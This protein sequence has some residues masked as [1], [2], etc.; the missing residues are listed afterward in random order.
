VTDSGEIGIFQVRYSNLLMM[1]LQQEQAILRGRVT[2]KAMSGAKQISPVQFL[3][4]ISTKIV[5]SRLNPIAATPHNYTRYWVQPTD[6]AVAQYVDTFDLLKTEI[7]PKSQL[8]A[9]AASACG[10]DWDD[11]IIRAATAAST[12]GTDGGSLTTESFDTTAYQ[13][14]GQFGASAAV[15]LTVAKLNEAYRIFEK[16]HI[17]P[18]QDRITLVIGSSEHR[19]LK[20]QAQVVSSD[21]NRN[22][23]VL[24]NGYVSEFMG[25]DIV[26]SERLPTITDKDSNAN[27]RGCLAFVKQGIHLNMWADLNTKISQADW[28][29]G[30]PWQIYT[31]HSF[32]AVRGQPGTV[33]QIAAADAYGAD[34]TP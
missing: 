33:V 22:G 8:V 23:G 9:S 27:Q 13:V 12:I 19:D 6:K 28:L 14:S 3:D 24:T 5:S 34:T 32:G 18:R 30:H 16:N 20:N 31:K 25:M 21:F 11:E 17:N 1:K 4:A 7:D 29:E 10:R 26:V 2:E 15:G